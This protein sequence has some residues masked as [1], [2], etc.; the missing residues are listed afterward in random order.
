METVTTQNA[1]FRLGKVR[2]FREVEVVG[3]FFLPKDL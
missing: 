2:V 3:V 1:A